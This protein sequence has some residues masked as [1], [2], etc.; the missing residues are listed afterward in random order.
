[1]KC[2]SDELEFHE[3]ISESLRIYSELRKL[4][5]AK[6]FLTEAEI[7]SVEELCMGFDK[8]T[9]HFPNGT[10]TRK[11]HELILDVPRFFGK[12]QNIRIR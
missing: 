6:R 11:M 2:S 8:F 12:A 7:L 9:I 10:V 1:M 5:L 4:I 3:H